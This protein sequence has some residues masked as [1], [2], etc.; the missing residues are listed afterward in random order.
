MWSSGTGPSAS[1]NVTPS[2]EWSSCSTPRLT[3]HTSPVRISCVRSPIVMVTEPSTI[4]ITCS[5]CSWLW[6]TTVVPGAYVTCPRKTWSPA[7]ALSP[8]PGKSGWGSRP[9]NVSNGESAT[10]LGR[11]LEGDPA[12]RDGV[13]GQLGVEHDRLPVARRLGL[14][15]ERAEHPLRRDRQLRHPDADGVVHCRRDRGRLRVVRHLPDAL[16]AVRAVR[17]GVLDDDRVDL[18]QV[19]EPGREVRA[20]L[21]AAV[22]GG[23]VVRVAVLEHAEPEALDGTALYLALDERRVDRAADVVDLDQARHPDDAGLV[24]DLDLGRAGGVRDRGVGRAV[25]LPR[26]GVDDRRE[27]L[28]L[29]PGARDQLAVRP[30][31]RGGDVGNGDLLLRRALGQHLAVHD[32]EVGGVDLELLARDVEDPLPDSL[33]RLLDRLARDERR[34]RRERPGADGR[35]VGVRVVVRDPVVRDADRLRDDLRLDRLRPVGDVGRA[36][37]DVD[38][39]VGLHLDPRL[40]RVAV[41]VH[42][43]RVLDR[44]DPAALVHSH[45]W[46][47]G[48]AIWPTRC[49]GSRSPSRGSRVIAA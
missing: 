39:T 15:L 25:D 47:S 32:L 48:F 20:E 40:R 13:H 19:L 16:R 31:R 38:A 34:T 23:G 30:R 11:D 21:T 7:T 42:A 29:R 1:M 35:R 41:L 9:S 6:R 4:S 14:R 49:S 8:T 3:T 46:S 45:Q 26:L 22:L 18:R 37:E 10:R 33:G 17:G 2:A 27:V 36:R 43:S 44:R 12:P 28:E 5:V 24:V